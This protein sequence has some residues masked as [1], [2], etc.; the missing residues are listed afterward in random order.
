MNAMDDNLPWN[1]TFSYGRALQSD[2]LSGWSGTNRKEGQPELMLKYLLK[3]HSDLRIMLG[4][5][6]FLA[7]NPK[8][9]KSFLL[10]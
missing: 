10:P 6:R 1:L 2:A 4:D 5:F 9:T 8:Q 3:K 7:S